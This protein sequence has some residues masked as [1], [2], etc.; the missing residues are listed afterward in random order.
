MSRRLA[1]CTVIVI[2]SYEEEKANYQ[3]RDASFH[4]VLSQVSL[5]MQHSKC[6]RLSRPAKL[7]K[8]VV[9]TKLSDV[10]IGV[11]VKMQALKWRTYTDHST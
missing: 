4:D 8:S 6:V 5:C 3:S 2:L 9:N 11:A 1:N 7:I 10:C